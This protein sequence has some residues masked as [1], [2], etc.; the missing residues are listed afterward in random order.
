M[1]QTGKRYDELVKSHETESYRQ[2]TGWLLEIE[3]LSE[4]HLVKAIEI[5]SLANYGGMLVPADGEHLII[6]LRLPTDSGIE[7]KVSRQIID[8][9][10]CKAALYMLCPKKD[11]TGEMDVASTWIFDGFQINKMKL[12]GF[13]RDHKSSTVELMMTCT[14]KEVRIV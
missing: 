8:Q 13:N 5:P 11:E 2:D 9:V 14:F 3:S 1:I 7:T 12:Q 6:V 10:R 4:S